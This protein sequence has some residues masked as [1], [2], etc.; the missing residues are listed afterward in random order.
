MAIR[1]NTFPEVH[2]GINIRSNGFFNGPRFPNRVYLT[3]TVC[4]KF[5]NSDSNNVLM[6][7]LIE[8]TLLHEMVHWGDHK[9]GVDQALIEEGKEFEKEAYGR[10]IERY[11]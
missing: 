3:K 10:D 9:D 1:L 5:E 7:L 11:W 2:F 8:S 6:H 4:D